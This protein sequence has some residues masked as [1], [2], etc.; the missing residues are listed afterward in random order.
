MQADLTLRTQPHSFVPQK[1][2]W[3]KRGVL[4]CVRAC[5]L[6]K[7]TLEVVDETQTHL[8]RILPVAC[9][10]L[11]CPAALLTDCVSLSFINFSHL[12]A[13]WKMIDDARVIENRWTHSSLMHLQFV[14]LCV[15]VNSSQMTVNPKA[16]NIV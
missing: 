7:C 6:A 8:K 11:N 5:A 13:I 3:E 12:P 1:V 9:W 2:E 14:C 10:P 4:A 15:F 16:R